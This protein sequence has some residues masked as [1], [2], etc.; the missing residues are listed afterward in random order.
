MVPWSMPN[1][2]EPWSPR[3]R[4]GASLGR[5]GSV[6]AGCDRTSERGMDYR[7]NCRKACG[8][9]EPPRCRD[10]I[11]GGA[12]IRFLSPIGDTRPADGHNGTPRSQLD[13]LDKTDL[14]R[15]DQS[16]RPDCVDVSFGGQHL[17]HLLCPCQQ[18]AP[19]PLDAQRTGRTGRPVN[20]GEIKSRVC[21]SLIYDEDSG[22]TAT[23]KFA[24]CPPSIARV[25][26]FCYAKISTSNSHVFF[27]KSKLIALFLATL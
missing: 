5:G 19:I 22:I 7:V 4:A 14:P 16:P 10:R 6:L 8:W 24:L 17:D 23:K 26:R 27:I 21:L 11:Y 9:S 18:D 25:L 2:S 20:L 1:K 13:R 12:F 3:C 15:V